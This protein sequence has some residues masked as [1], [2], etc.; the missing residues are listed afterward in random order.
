MTNKFQVLEL[1]DAHPDWSSIRLAAALDCESA[2]V[3]A[4]LSRNGRVLAT[5][6]AT[7]A[8]LRRKAGARRRRA[9]RLIAEAA[10][11]EQ[12][13]SA[14]EAGLPASSDPETR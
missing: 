3:R 14:N 4:T 9:D 7:P 6:P 2:Y 1:F 12:R 10:E 13:A 5:S 11:L 8:W